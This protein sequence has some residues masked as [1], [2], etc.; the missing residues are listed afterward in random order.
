MT[1]L[2]SSE[3]TPAP[4]SSVQTPDRG[5]SLVDLTG[6]LGGGDIPFDPPKMHFVSRPADL[7]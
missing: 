6:M 7:S 1:H 3:G 4:E 2:P 5:N